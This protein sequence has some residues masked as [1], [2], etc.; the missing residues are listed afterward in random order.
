MGNQVY[1]KHT[2]TRNK[3]SE[4]VFNREV[5]LTKAPSIQQPA[6]ASYSKQQ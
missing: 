6:S 3:I 5:H 4:T 2:A 1:N